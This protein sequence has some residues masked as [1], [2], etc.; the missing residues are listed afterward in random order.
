[1]VPVIQALWLALPVILA[2]LSHVLVLDRGWLAPLGRVPLD[3]G[4]RVRGR[5][6]FGANKTVRGALVMIAA[7]SGWALC[8]E[9]LRRALGWPADVTFA[10]LARTGPG[11]WG[12]LLGAAY[13]AGELPNSFVKRQLDIAPGAPAKGR[14][15]VLLWLIDQTDSLAGVLVAVSFV[16]VPPVA[17]IATLVVIALVIHPAVAAVMVALGL[18][19]RIG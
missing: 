6:L 5:R 12:A 4:A 15:R 11:W 16:A 18:K 1:M 7:A 8:L 10:E 2:G 17:V 13:I 9:F 3:G 19:D 14:A